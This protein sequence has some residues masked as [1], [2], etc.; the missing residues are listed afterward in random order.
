MTGGVCVVLPA[1]IL[2]GTLFGSVLR[3]WSRNAQEQVAIATGVADEAIGNIRTVRAFA[4]EESEHRL[5][6]ACWGG[7]SGWRVDIFYFRS[8]H[9]TYIQAVPATADEVRVGQ[10]EA[11]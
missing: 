7:M 2:V 6:C 8:S 4:M 3:K 10:C 5:V 9:T 11:W 1:I